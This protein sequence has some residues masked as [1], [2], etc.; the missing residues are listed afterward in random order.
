MLFMPEDSFDK[1]D[2]KLKAN[3]SEEATRAEREQ[4]QSEATAAFVDAVV[5]ILEEYREKLRQ[6]NIAV[7][8][9]HSRDGFE[10]LMH[11][12]NGHQ[13]GFQLIK[14]PRSSGYVVL[15]LHTDER[16]GR[17]YTAEGTVEGG[18]AT[19]ASQGPTWNANEFR[20]YID[21]QIG[22]FI[23]GAARHGG[24]FRAP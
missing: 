1:I 20:K 13:F 3:A 6:R 7:D 12:R 11:Y 17:P 10:F 21:R 5:P 15:G 14:N 19:W 4:S 22:E 2:Q 23:D 24:G 18:P 9:K 16:T 8:L